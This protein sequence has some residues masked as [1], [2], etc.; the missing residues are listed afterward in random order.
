MKTIGFTQEQV[1]KI[2]EKIANEKKEFNKVMRIAIKALMRAEREEFNK[3][4]SDISN[5]YRPHR[6]LGKR[7]ELHFGYAFV[8][9][10]SFA[11]IKKVLYLNNKMKTKYTLLGI[12]SV[13]PAK[14]LK[15]I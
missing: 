14:F 7:K 4:N 9:F 6:F 1:T 8:S 10:F 2:L 3:Q 12:L 15:N 13:T 5:G 11:K